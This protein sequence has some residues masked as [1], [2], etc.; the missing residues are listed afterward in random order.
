VSKRTRL[1]LIALVWAVAA[2]LCVLPSAWPWYMHLIGTR[3]YR[4]YEMEAAGFSLGCV[5]MY[6][7]TRRTHR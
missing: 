5:T 2:V 3:T 4:A 7:M 1:G 6:V